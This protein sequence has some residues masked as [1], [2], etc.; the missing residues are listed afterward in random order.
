M[1]LRKI[2]EILL[3]ACVY[4]VSAKIGQTFAIGPGNVTPVWFPSG[5]IFFIIL[6]RGYAILPGVFLGAAIGNG[7]AY[8]SFEDYQQTITT[9]T[10]ASL[11]GIG[12]TLYA[13]IGVY[14]VKKATTINNFF[15]SFQDI[16]TFIVY[17]VIFASLVSAI[18]GVTGLFLAD[19]ITSNEYWS[20]FT[21]WFIGDAVGVLLFAPLLITLLQNQWNFKFHPRLFFYYILLAIFIFLIPYIPIVNQ[22]DILHILIIA[23]PILIYIAFRVDQFSALFF[24][25][26]AS[27]T[28]LISNAFTN[29][30]IDI[31]ELNQVLISTQLFV[32]LL[33]TIL[34]FFIVLVNILHNEENKRIEQHD[35]ML[36]SQQNAIS[37]MISMIAHQWRQPLAV[38]SMQVN[39][40]L[41]DI[42]LKNF[43]TSVATQNL[44][45]LQEQVS[46]LSKTMDDFGLMHNTSNTA[47]TRVNINEPILK[48]ISLLEKTFVN[49][50][51][52][53]V[54]ELHSNSEL[55]IL[56]GEMLQVILNIL[57]NARYIL[58][59]RKIDNPLVYIKT[60]DSKDNTTIIIGNN[61]GGIES[62]HIDKIFDAYYTTKEEKNN[63]GLG[64]Y[65][66]K[67]IIE[68]NFGGT[69]WF[70]N[71][72]NGVEFTINLPV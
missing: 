61:G 11:N 56:E 6:W 52:R 55:S 37:E 15:T 3:L 8:C 13:L 54:H 28:V 45:E 49:N 66:C 71:T 10:A 36:K 51:I 35:L 67:I 12:D 31:N 43:N 47:N 14:Y 64:L 30:H 50:K 7:W 70:D 41:F 23:I 22:F 19:L 57:N 9:L 18:F 69:I 5:I 4:I 25:T 48:A 16:I 21:T 27:L 59:S 58:I 1:T 17:A 68:K 42:E 34:L 38:I 39:N 29:K 44:Y 2:V 40:I 20:L 24:A 63:S 53:I 60:N 65:M 62:K 46:Y 72:E 26:L 32:F 33:F